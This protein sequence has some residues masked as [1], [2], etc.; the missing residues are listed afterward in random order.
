MGRRRKDKTLRSAMQ[1]NKAYISYRQRLMGLAIS[2]FEWKNIPPSMDERFLEQTLLLTGQCIVF[3]D[4]V[5]GMLNLQCSIG[6]PLSVYNIPLQRRAYA[7]NGY[8]KQL[9]EKDSVI[10]YNNV[11]RTNSILDIEMYCEK[12]YLLDRVLEIN[13]NAQKTP[14]VVLCSENQRLTFQNLMKEYDGNEVFLWGDKSLD[15]SQVKALKTDAPFLAKDIQIL[16]Q[17]IWNE[18]LTTLGI[19][20][21]STDKKERMVSNEVD[22]NMGSVI[23]QQYIRL[24]T[25]KKACEEIN[26]MFGTNISVDFRNDVIVTRESELDGDVNG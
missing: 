21:L 5:L 2:M 11:M 15:L 19:A 12:L 9:D 24:N 22:L 14:V 26:N 18:A 23:A 3:E 10:V 1:N 20:N 17:Q 6:A 16:K 8:Q 13:I 4:D 25:R 7:V